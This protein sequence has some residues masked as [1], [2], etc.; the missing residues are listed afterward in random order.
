SG[1]VGLDFV[2]EEVGAVA[3]FVHLLHHLGGEGGGGGGG[4][5]AAA[6]DRGGDDRVGSAA[7]DQLD[8]LLFA[9]GG[10]DV[11][12]RREF[13]D[14]E[15]DQDAG[16]VVVRDDNRL[17]GLLDVGIAEHVFSAGVALQAGEAHAG[18][19]VHGHPVGIHHD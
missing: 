3:V 16:L 7:Q 11:D 2:V 6:A 13:A 8:I 9:G 1:F 19:A 12:V 4:E 5:H 14:G 18:R 17:A 10:A 15:A